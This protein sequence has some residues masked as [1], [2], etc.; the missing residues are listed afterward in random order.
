MS[1][2]GEKAPSNI[3]VTSLINAASR[4]VRVSLGGVIYQN[5]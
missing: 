3:H 5:R 4:N 2:D 1:H